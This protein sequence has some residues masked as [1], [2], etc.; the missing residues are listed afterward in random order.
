[1]EGESV[2]F[3]TPKPL[4]LLDRIL[5]LATTNDKNSIILDFSLGQVPRLTQL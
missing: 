5:H 3:D 1:M 4:R 2:F